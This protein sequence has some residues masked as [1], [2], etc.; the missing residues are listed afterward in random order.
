VGAF[1]PM[2]GPTLFQITLVKAEKMPS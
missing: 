1:F 2:V